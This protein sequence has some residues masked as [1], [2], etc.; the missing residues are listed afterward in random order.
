MGKR[1]RKSAAELAI[2][3]LIEIEP[4]PVAPSELTDEESEIWE[5]I[6]ARMPAA[7]FTKETHPLLVQLCRHIIAAR[8]L[9]QLYHR[10]THGDEDFEVLYYIKLVR[11]LVGQTAIIASIST[12]MRLT[13]Q[14][15]YTDK[16]AGTAKR[17][18]PDGPA[19]WEY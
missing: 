14:S 8:R 10:A 11:A 18:M 4:R 5:G 9:A 1:G 19:P 6:V 17:N 7:W 13:Q 12:K 2:A 3:P 15:S 16:A